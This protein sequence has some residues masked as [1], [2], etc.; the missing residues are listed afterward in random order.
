MVGYFGGMD[1]LNRQGNRTTA[2]NLAVVIGVV[3]AFNLQEWLG[4]RWELGDSPSMASEDIRKV[5]ELFATVQGLEA[6]R[7][8]GVRFAAERRITTMR[9]TQI[10]ST[11]VFVGL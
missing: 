10:V 7:Y 9:G 4:G 5:I 2:F 11:V 8:I 6:S 1:W 3:V